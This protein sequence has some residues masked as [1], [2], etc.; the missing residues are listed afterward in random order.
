MKLTTVLY[1]TLCGMFL[2]PISCTSEGEPLPD[3][4]TSI[5]LKVSDI[6]ASPCGEE[7]GLI[8]LLIGGGDGQYTFMVDKKSYAREDG[9][10]SQLSAGT[11]LIQVQDGQ[12]CTGEIE[13]HVP[14]ATKLS[15]IQ[16]L[17]D[18][19][20]AVSGCHVGSN[21][22]RVNLKV[23]THIIDRYADIQERVSLGNMPPKDSDYSL[24]PEEILLITCWANDG[25]P[26]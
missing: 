19:N 2:L 1:P 20:C 24:T 5:N 9:I 13:V 4:D 15:H 22:A 25:G 14:S 6:Q 3:C 10:F 18:S 23:K 26:E 11:H 16:P 21:P 7:S 17:L 12:D 8:R